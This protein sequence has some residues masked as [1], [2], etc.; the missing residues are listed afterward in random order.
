MVTPGVIAENISLIF[1]SLLGAGRFG[2]G[3]QAA[4]VGNGDWLSVGGGNCGGGMGAVAVG[5]WGSVIG[6]A[7]AH[8]AAG[9]GA[10][11]LCTEP[12][13]DWCIPECMPVGGAGGGGGAGFSWGGG[14]GLSWS[15][16]VGASEVRGVV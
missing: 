5:G 2:G 10:A 9:R 8:W 13:A 15:A 16:G 6:C 12:H 1:A 14:T 7:G 4:E 3:Y 11:G